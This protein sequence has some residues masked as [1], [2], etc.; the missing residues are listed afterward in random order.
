MHQ[1]SR[2]FGVT[3]VAASMMVSLGAPAVARTWTHTSMGGYVSVVDKKISLK[4]NA[5]DGK[6]VTTEFRYNDGK[7][8]AALANK[9]GYGKTTSAT[10][11]SNI[12]ND[13]ICRSN[14]FPLP[15][16][17]GSWRW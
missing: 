14:P 15:M 6:F 11:S 12:T 4:D 17:C 5:G 8:S 16:D 7:S 9:L 2:R 3:L 10:M 1:F 13:K